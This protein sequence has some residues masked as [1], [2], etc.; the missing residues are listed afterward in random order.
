[1]I[2]DA[3]ELTRMEGI[4]MQG[5]KHDTYEESNIAWKVTLATSVNGEDWTDVESD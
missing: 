4:V 3:G 2:I 1:M 5:A